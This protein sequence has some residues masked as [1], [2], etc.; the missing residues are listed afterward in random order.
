MC[1]IAGYIAT[2]N[3]DN[4]I[5]KEMTNIFAHRG[6]DAEGYY[7]DRMENGKTVAFGHR[8][9]SI[10][11]LSENGKQ[12]MTSEDGNIVTTYNGEIYNYIE[13]RDE[14]IRKGY[15]F[16]SDCDT[17]VII[18]AY[19][20][21]GIESVNRFNGMF[22]YCI[23]DKLKQEVYLVRDRIGKKPLYYYY[24]GQS[25]CF[26][27]DLKAITL[28][29]GF[30]KSLNYEALHMF[31]WNQYIVAPYT[32]YQNTF[33]LKQGSILKYKNGNI[34]IKCYWDLYKKFNDRMVESDKSEKQLGKELEEL[35]YDSV[36]KRMIADVP[37]GVFLSGGIDSSLITAIAQNSSSSKMDTFSIG[38]YEDGFN[39]AGYAKEV[40]KALGTNHH[41]EYISMSDA[42]RLVRDVPKYYTEPFADNSQLPML[43]LSKFTRES[44][45][46]ALSGDG[47]D[48]LFCGYTS[49]EDVM[50]LKKYIPIASLISFVGNRYNL[51]RNGNRKLWM[52]GK[53]LH[54]TNEDNILVLDYLTSCSIVNTLFDFEY[55]IAPEYFV[56]EIKTD[57]ISEKRMLLD[58]ATYL[59]DDIMAKVDRASMAY[60]LESRAPFL[61]YRVIEKSFQ[62]PYE[63]KNKDGNL[64]NILKNILYEYVPK[65]LMDRPKK[66]F[67]V[68][69]TQW[70]HGDFMPLIDEYF[71]DGLIKSQNVFDARGIRNFVDHFKYK[72]TVILDKIMWSLLMFQMWYEDNF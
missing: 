5:L 16:R 59:P 71:S 21:W 31:L 11:D 60:S 70:L 43:L 24:D 63:Y 8:R 35:L 1:G 12:P 15:S 26:A 64:K 46:V 56:G 18:K 65:E 38:F 14:L 6:P 66:G 41:E 48:E 29:P 72:P 69:L 20:E 4:A 33:K 19:Q 45:T 39:E 28:F 25:I 23:Y 55:G 49:Y 32:I 50:K 53:A 40:A 68:P 3:I 62:I 52:L 17:E 67:G 42:A 47:G 13:I 9:L 27:S 10:L 44:V 30:S 54:C 22:A 51:H 61:D 58:I 7:Y 2:D 37:L 57:N 34:D 36:Q